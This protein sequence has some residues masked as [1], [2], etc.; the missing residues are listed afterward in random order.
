[1]KKILAL[2]LSLVML[3]ALAACAPILPLP[4]SGGSGSAG[5]TGGSPFS[6]TPEPTQAPTAVGTWELT[7]RTRNGQSWEYDGYV[8][9]AL[10]PGGTG[11]VSDDGHEDEL[12]W[13][14]STLTLYGETVSYTLSGDTMR[15]SL[16]DMSFVFTRISAEPYSRSGGQPA[17]I[18]EDDPSLEMAPDFRMTDR[19]GNTVSLSDFRGKPVIINFWATWCGPCQME[20]PYFNEAYAAYGDQ[21]HFLMVDLVDG[22][23]ETESG[24]MDFVDTNG[25]RFPLYFDYLGEGSSLYQVTAIPMTVAINSYGR[26]VDTHVGSMSREELQA[27][28]DKLI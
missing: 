4:T 2:V 12:A 14:D 26:I 6:L 27:L 1:M 13:N 25:Y 15:F 7:Q 20:L 5:G 19:S 3:L 22:S 10:E 23:Y 17:V 16:D 11:F 24:T 18:E 9:L 28:I 8:F 21:I